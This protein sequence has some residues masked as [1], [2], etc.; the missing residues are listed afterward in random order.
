MEYVDLPILKGEVGKGGGACTG[1]LTYIVTVVRKMNMRNEGLRKLKLLE[2]EW[3]LFRGYY[4]IRLHLL[5][6]CV[7]QIWWK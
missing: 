4:V 6:Q 3:L 5:L 1:S 2:Q 7:A